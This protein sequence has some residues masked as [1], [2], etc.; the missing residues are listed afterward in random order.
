MPVITVWPTLATTE[1]R[2]VEAASWEPLFDRLR[3]Y[4]EQPFRGDMVQPGWS[5]ARF[6]PTVREDVNVKSLTA[7]VLD[8]DETDPLEAAEE[9]WGVFYGLIHTT[10]RHTNAAHRFRV[11]L[12]LSREITPE[13]YALLWR[14][15]VRTSGH[16]VD[17]KTRNPS[18]FWFVPGTS[19]GGAFHSARLTGPTMD[20]DPLLVE[21]AHEEEQRASATV[22]RIYPSAESRADR[23]AQAAIDDECNAVGMAGPGNRNNRLFIAACTAGNFIAAGNLAESY[24]L[25]RLTTA[26]RVC[27]LPTF[28][29]LR[30][31]RSGIARGMKS[32]RQIPE[33]SASP[34]TRPD[35]TPRSTSSVPPK[36]AETHRGQE[37][38]PKKKEP[39][40]YKTLS[41]FV[42]T[43]LKPLGKRLETGFSTLDE[44]TRGGIPLGRV[45][46]LAGAPG[47]SKTTLAAFLVDTWE[48]SGCAIVYLAAD[49][50]ADGI[51]TRLGQLA[52]FSRDGLET[53][54]EI[55]DAVRAGFAARSEGRPLVVI[56]PDE[57]EHISSIEDAEAVLLHLAGDRP[58]V[59]VVDSLQ[60][61]RC[62]AAEIAESAKERID[63]KLRVIKGIA[64]RGTLVIAISEMA[65]SGYRSNDRRDNISALAAGKESGSIEYGAA[66]LLGL[67]PVKGE[68][69][70]VDVEVAKNRLGGQKPELR[71]KLDA[72]RAS[73]IEVALPGAEEEE[74]PKAAPQRMDRAKERIRETLRKHHDLGSQREVLA[75]TDG[76]R[77]HNRDAFKDMEK[78]GEVVLVSGL[79]RLHSEGS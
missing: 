39:P 10:R 79:Y 25:D 77:D 50:P 28:E 18:R 62:I 56:D 53:E 26:A 49:E 12:P 13:K 4:G 44:A 64:K 1:G 7:L 68:Q 16:R 52:G 36:A 43:C 37:S 54:G 67:R 30:T 74:A 15:V 17:I 78:R 47:A 3:A 23:Y 19:D 76:T 75:H 71:M 22:T 58:R 34:G 33:P 42:R 69:G 51:V 35:A 14:Y 24:A 61:S 5:A 57:D 8:Y 63:L 31:I 6:E 48:K 11:I 60:T 72:D 27:K 20:P 66:L 73:F 9:M 32:P 29:A 21:A 40:R 70:Q 41:E 65:R 46:V 2:M 55:G 59:L 45:V 38:A